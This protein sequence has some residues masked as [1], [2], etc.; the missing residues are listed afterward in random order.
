MKL[1][2]TLIQSSLDHTKFSSEFFG[3]PDWTDNSS[4]DAVGYRKAIVGCVRLNFD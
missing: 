1:K 2:T 4:W 3:N